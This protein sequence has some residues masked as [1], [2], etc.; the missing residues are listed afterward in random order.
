MDL[1]KDLVLEDG[2][3]NIITDYKNSMETTE[4][5]NKV[6]KEFKEK[7]EYHYDEEED[8]DSI[9]IIDGYQRKYSLDGYM[10]SI[11]MVCG[12]RRI[13]RLDD[14]FMSYFQMY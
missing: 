12:L 3:V 14:F 11:E 7:V 4:K 8:Y 13:V 10:L 5:Y 1:L 9:I 2:V 6:M